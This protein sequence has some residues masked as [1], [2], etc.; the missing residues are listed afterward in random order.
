[1]L[2]SQSY[3]AALRLPTVRGAYYLDVLRV[4]RVRVGSGVRL[5]A[6]KAQ[7]SRLKGAHCRADCELSPAHARTKTYFSVGLQD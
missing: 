5:K 1:M 7:G 6:L 3:A 4:V 2:L